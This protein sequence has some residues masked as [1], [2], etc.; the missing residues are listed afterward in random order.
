MFNNYKEIIYF[1]IELIINKLVSKLIE[2][3]LLFY[4][5]FIKSTLLLHF[6]I[7]KKNEIN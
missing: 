2:T 1:N 5:Y 6:F 4:D 7:N 3:F